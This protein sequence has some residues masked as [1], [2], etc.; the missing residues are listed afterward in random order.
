MTI[1]LL[2]FNYSYMHAIIIPRELFTSVITLL[3]LLPI[4]LRVYV[5]WC[6]NRV[7]KK[8]FAYSK[9]TSAYVYVRNA[10]TMYNGRMFDI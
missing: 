3:M 2:S 1:V 10:I 8:Y 4:T 7:S 9:G 5:C 6:V